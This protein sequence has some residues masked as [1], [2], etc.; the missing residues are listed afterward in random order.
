[1]LKCFW[2]D[3]LVLFCISQRFAGPQNLVLSSVLTGVERRK[4]LGKYSVPLGARYSGFDSKPDPH[5]GSFRSFER[6]FTAA[7]VIERAGPFRTTGTGMTARPDRPRMML[8]EPASTPSPALR[9]L[10]SGP[11]S[12]KPGSNE[13][14]RVLQQVHERKR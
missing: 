6:R 11:F 3:A 4:R 9:P 12:I 1:M 13:V 8:Q 14:W 7:M 5:L 2:Q 10:L